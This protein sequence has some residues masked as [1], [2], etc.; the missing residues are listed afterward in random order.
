MNKEPKAPLMLNR[1]ATFVPF[2]PVPTFCSNINGII[3]EA[4]AA[5][6]YAGSTRSSSLDGHEP[7]VTLTARID[8]F[9][10]NSQSAG[11]KPIPNGHEPTLRPAHLRLRRPA[12]H[13]E[14][15]N[16]PEAVQQAGT[17]TQATGNASDKLPATDDLLQRPRATSPPRV[18]I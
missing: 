11:T 14:T 15:V 12:G 2:A 6:K 4:I 10:C 9:L 7:T 16:D 3:V 8:T 18:R 13:T 1:F 17:A 5:D